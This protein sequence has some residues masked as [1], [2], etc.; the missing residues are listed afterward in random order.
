VVE[1]GVGGGYAAR[2]GGGWLDL[3][4]GFLFCEALNLDLGFPF[5]GRRGG[6]VYIAWGERW[7]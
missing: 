5:H 2:H 4:L 6:H 7:H 3:D 1:H